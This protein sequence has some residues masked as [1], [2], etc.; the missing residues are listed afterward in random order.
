MSKKRLYLLFG[1]PV[2]FLTFSSLH[3][4]TGKVEPKG[5]PMHPLCKSCHQPQPNVMMGFLDSI[6]YKNKVIQIDIG[7][8]KELVKFTDKVKLAGLKDL[9]EIKL[10]RGRGFSIEYEEKKGEKIAKSITRFDVM[11]IIPK[12]DQ[13]SR[14]ALEK[15]LREDKRVLLLDSRPPHVYQELHIPLAKNLPAPAFDKVAPKILPQDKE[16]TIIYYDIGGCLSPINYMNTKAQGYKN[17]KIYVA[18][19][20]DWIQAKP[21][22]TTVE[23]LSKAVQ[24]KIGYV[25]IDIRSPEK[26]KDGFIPTAVNI[27]LKDL[28]QSKALFPEKKTA[29]IIVYGDNMEEVK[30]AAEIIHGFGYRRT[31][32]LPIPFEEWIKRGLPVDKGTP[33][34]QIVFIPKP[35]PGTI[36]VEEFEKIVKGPLPKDVYLIDVRTPEEFRKGHFKGAVNIPVDLLTEKAPEIPKDKRIILYCETGIRAEM[37]YTALKNLG[38]KSEYL[39]AK[40]EF[41]GGKF[42]ITEN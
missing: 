20:P 32:Y 42:S 41:K 17:V 26:L 31:A 38:I 21:A 37:G 1:A 22:S 2:L 30:S 24:E 25:L 11:K 12:D 28:P 36:P 5:G 14:E 23:F 16:T 33:A 10:Y 29:F 19:L 3:S 13:L 9:E 40:V 34:K 6:S 18:G 27:P 4:Q 15:I 39:D 8:T 7:A 35:K